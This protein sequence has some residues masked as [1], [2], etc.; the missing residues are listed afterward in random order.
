MLCCAGT[1]GSAPSVWGMAWAS[2]QIFECVISGIGQRRIRKLSATLGNEDRKVKVP[3]D[4]GPGASSS[5]RKIWN[6]TGEV[7]MD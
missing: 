3:A 6:G 2:W 5:P 7:R 4:W 1:Q